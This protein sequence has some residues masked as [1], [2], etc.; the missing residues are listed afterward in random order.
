MKN[1]KVIFYAAELIKILRRIDM[2][3]CV[4]PLK[5]IHFNRP[6]QTHARVISPLK[7][8]RDAN[9]HTSESK[10]SLSNQRHKSPK[11]CIEV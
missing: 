10:T 3:L 4:I 9:K 5:E 1:A 2:G 7:R 8:E 6:C 11:I